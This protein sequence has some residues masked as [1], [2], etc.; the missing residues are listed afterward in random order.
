MNHKQQSI[1]TLS[2]NQIEMNKQYLNDGIEMNLTLTH[3]KY[4]R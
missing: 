1:A 4:Q 2:L 3:V